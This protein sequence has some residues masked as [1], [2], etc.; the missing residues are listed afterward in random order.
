MKTLFLLAGVIAQEQYPP[1]DYSNPT[2][3]GE[4]E[5]SFPRQSNI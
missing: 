2:V 3:P 5:E 4:F 1:L